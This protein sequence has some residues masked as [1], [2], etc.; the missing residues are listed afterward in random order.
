MVKLV[1]IICILFYTHSPYSLLH[2]VCNEHISAVQ[3]RRREQD[4]PLNAQTN[5]PKRQKYPATRYNRGVE[6]NQG[7][8]NA[9]HNCENITLRIKTVEKNTLITT[10]SSSQLQKHQA[11]RMFRRIAGEERKY[12]AR[13]AD[14]QGLQQ[15][16]QTQIA[17]RAT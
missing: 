4:T 5:V 15:G 14:I 1:G 2:N 17:P 9:V 11:S 13:M 16:P 8:V 3:V 7:Y 6:H 12:R 10:T